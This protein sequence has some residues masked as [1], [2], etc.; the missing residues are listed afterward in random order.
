[1]RFLIAGGL[2]TLRLVSAKR[3]KEIG[4]GFLKGR[5]R[6][7]YAAAAEDFCQ[8]VLM[9]RLYRK[10]AEAI[11]RHLDAG[12]EAVLLTASPTFYLEPLRSMLGFSAV[13]GTE[14]AADENGRFTGEIEGRN[15]RGEQKPLRLQAYMEKAGAQMDAAA[16][17]A[18]GDSAHDLPMLRMVGHAYA[19][20]PGKKL[21]QKLPE[22]PNAAVLRWKETV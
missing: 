12:H 9:P 14:Y 7:E 10:G 19:V 22:L 8:T 17:S 15:C 4:L 16:S 3:G 5:S 20:N 6:A 11:R 1:M 13:L 2:F 21:I 18:Y